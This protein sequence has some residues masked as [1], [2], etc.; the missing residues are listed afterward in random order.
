M[1]KGRGERE[2]GRVERER[3][4][5]RREGGRGEGGRGEEREEERG[6]CVCVWQAVREGGGSGRQ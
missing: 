2:G 3:G 1:L 4:R 6:E 5:E